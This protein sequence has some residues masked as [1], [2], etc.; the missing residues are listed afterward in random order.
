MP[1][2]KPLC[3][4]H[5]PLN[6]RFSHTL[7]VGAAAFALLLPSLAS[8]VALTNNPATSNSAAVAELVNAIRTAA[9]NHSAT[10]IKLFP[11]GVYTLTQPD[12][13]EYGP[14][15]LPQISGDITINGRG[16]MLLRAT[17]APPF[18]FFYVSGGLS[19]DAQTK[20][21]LPAGSLTLKNLT[22]QGGLAHG[23]KGSGEGG[24]GAGMGGAIFNQGTLTLD[25]VTLTQNTAQ[26]GNSGL[27]TDPASTN[28]YGGG[29]GIGQDA[30][31][32][33]GGGFGGPFLGGGG[34]GGAGGVIGGYSGGGGGGG[35]RPVDNGFA[36]G[37]NEF[38]AGGGLGGLG[39]SYRFSDGGIGGYGYPQSNSN[40]LAGGGYGF[41]GQGLA[42]D[43]AFASDIGGGGGGIGGG[44]GHGGGQDTDG[45][46]G[47]GG[48]GAGG[49]DLGGDGGFG[50]GGGGG[51]SG[52]FAGFAGGFGGPADN[53]GGGGGGLG[54]AIFNHRGSLFLTNCT[55]A[56]NVAG[57][58]GGLDPT[59]EKLY[60]G[61]S[62]GGAGYGGGIFNLNGTA[63]IT[64]CTLAS[65]FTVPGVT[66]Y[67]FGPPGKMTNI[68][69]G[70]SDGGALYT[71][72]YGN[73][74]EDGS[75]SLA[76]VTLRN[77]ILADSVGS[78]HD[79]LNR[80]LNGSQTN[81]S[82]VIFCGPNLVMSWTNTTT[83]TSSN[84]PTVTANPKLGP[85]AN[86][87]GLTPTM[88]LLPG[89]PAID[90]GD[91]FG[92]TTDQRGQPRPFV[93]CDAGPFPGDGSDIGAYEFDSPIL[94]I[95][96]C[97]GGLVLSWSTKFPG[98]ALQS[99]LTP[100]QTNSWANVGCSPV[101]AG[102]NYV[103][104]NSNPAGLLFYRL[105]GS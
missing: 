2:M 84:A 100:N 10:V 15:G 4:V 59:L 97:P 22:L 60:N 77:S 8:A 1:E 16:A 20:A 86:N 66:Y 30:I 83:S 72:A 21:G 13:W 42:N 76:Q 14:N 46:G 28:G 53:D 34:M 95:A 68:P 19:Y 47:F 79:L 96:G 98:C 56:A 37:T 63:S 32:A 45:S 3:A 17:N 6:R 82:V 55:F 87:G 67:F 102:C 80:A 5:A 69:T 38:G 89:S 50:G 49:G 99:T 103:V 62:A 52:A 48:G 25:D 40:G 7:L 75:A 18:R 58:G 93:L 105:K 74:I 27:P 57:G 92:L 104:T 94:H 24:G 9:T 85:L 33:I 41:G 91:S 64:S 36:V 51:N 11:N 61:A 39:T 70:G 31:G 81:S 90:Q 101:I 44:G 54:G 23:G 78:G 73:R 29:G 35:F 26:G 71:V 43:S 12:N 65:N 88:A